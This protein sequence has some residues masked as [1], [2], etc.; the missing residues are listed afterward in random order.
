MNLTNNIINMKLQKNQKNRTLDD[1]N[2][3]R[4]FKLLEKS[5]QFSENICKKKKVKFP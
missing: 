4:I 2:L 3:K 1:I 5:V